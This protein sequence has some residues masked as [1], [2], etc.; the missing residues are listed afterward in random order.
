MYSICQYFLISMEHFYLC[1]LVSLSFHFH[2]Y[3]LTWCAASI[4]QK[5]NLIPISCFS[6]FVTSSL[7]S[8]VHA[9]EYGRCWSK[10]ISL[11]HTLIYLLSWTWASS[12]FFF[13]LLKVAFFVVLFFLSV[14]WSGGVIERVLFCCT[15][16]GLLDI[17]SF[18]CFPFFA[19]ADAFISAQSVGFGVLI[20]AATWIP[21]LGFLS[22]L[23]EIWCDLNPSMLSCWIWRACAVWKLELEISCI[24]GKRVSFFVDPILPYEWTILCSFSVAVLDELKFELSCYENPVGQGQIL[25]LEKAMWWICFAVIVFFL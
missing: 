20:C 15:D 9:H 22:Y 24:W 12:L 3:C 23:F 6:I 2:L 25:L 13:F 19:D 16:F 14:V 8:F 4:P 10:V 7:S 5:Q 17:I 18:T 11:R 1:F 21:M